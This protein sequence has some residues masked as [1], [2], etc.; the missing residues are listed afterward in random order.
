MCGA[1]DHARFKPNSDRAADIRKGSPPKRPCGAQ[2][3]MLL[4]G[5]VREDGQCTTFD[6]VPSTEAW[7]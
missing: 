4:R 7:P 6:I 1:P 2:L 5:D 3:A